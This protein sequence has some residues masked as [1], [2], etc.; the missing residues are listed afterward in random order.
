MEELLGMV[1]PC[2]LPTYPR[3]VESNQNVVR[4]IDSPQF[5]YRLRDGVTSFDDTEIS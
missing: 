5:D 1:V 2:G 4:E 3:E